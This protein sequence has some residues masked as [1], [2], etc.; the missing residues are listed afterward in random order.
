MAYIMLSNP[1][2]YITVCILVYQIANISKGIATCEHSF[3]SL[4]F[5]NWLAHNHIKTYT[6]Y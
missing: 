2:L 6:N 5:E 3:A 1:Y 4:G